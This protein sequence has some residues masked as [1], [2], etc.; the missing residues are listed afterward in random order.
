MKIAPN[1]GIR[2]QA[3][4]LLKMLKKPNVP[5]AKVYGLL[6]NL[7]RSADKLLGIQTLSAS[8]R[9]PQW[10]IKQ[11]QHTST[12]TPE[13]RMKELERTGWN[14]FCV[15]AETIFLDLLTDSGTGAPSDEM[16]AAIMAADERYSHSK[17]YERFVPIAQAIFNKMHILPVNQGRAGENI[18][19]QVLLEGLKKEADKKGVELVCLGNT[20]FDTTFAISSRQGALVINSPCPESL[21]TNTAFPF[22]GNADVEKMRQAIKDY[23]S[24]NVGFIVMTVVNNTIGGQPVSMENQRAVH[25]LAKEHDILYIL[26]AARIFENA[27]LIKQRE[28]GYENKSI[29]EIVHEMTDLADVVIMSAKKDAIANMGGIIATQHEDLYKAFKAL[30]IMIVGH[31]SYGGM[32]GRDLAALTVGLQEG[33]EESHLK[34]RIN[35]VAEFGHGFRRLGFPIQ[36]PPGSNGIYMDGRAFLNEV[37]PLF[38]PAQRICA[39]IYWRYGIRPVEIGL[40]LAG[41]DNSGMRV[42]PEKDLIR[43]T[44]PRRTFT[45]D[46]MDFVLEALAQ[47]FSERKNI[48]GLILEEEGEGNGH[49]TNIF[50]PVS[51]DEIPANRK[52]VKAFFAQPLKTYSSGYLPPNARQ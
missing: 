42:F 27:Y 39:E 7:G 34:A 51:R 3:A 47:L 46:H 35:Q 19:F 45:K 40:S 28:P 36:W 17:T 1:A 22:K 23:G 32:S 5:A 49:F 11:I 48:G 12:A 43:F 20:Y 37:D 26:D 6:K 16:F 2:R 13:V 44:I 15:K 21:D 24:E 31:Y 8:E 25:Q 50:R 38:F 10:T 4:Q 9:A 29:Q 41:R 14:V 30:E 52:A 18:V 33:M